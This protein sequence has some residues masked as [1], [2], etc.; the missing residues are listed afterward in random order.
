MYVE[1][2]N[3][4]TF[5]WISHRPY[6]HRHAD[7]EPGWTFEKQHGHQELHRGGSDWQPVDAFWYQIR[8][9][10][11]VSHLN[12]DRKGSRTGRPLSSS[13]TAFAFKSRTMNRLFSFM[14]V[15]VCVSLWFTWMKS[16][17][18][19]VIH[20]VS[21]PSVSRVTSRLIVELSSETNVYSL[22]PPR[23]ELV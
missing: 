14:C 22:N 12:V 1:Y 11:A 4:H 16:Q 8:T 13:F 17:I 9:R 2:T 19:Y 5:L 23:L 21:S 10:P 6:N 20:Y 18:H 3:I 7:L 15:C